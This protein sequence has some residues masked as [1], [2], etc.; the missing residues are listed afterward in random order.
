MQTSIGEDLN[1]VD[2]KAAE[3]LR[4]VRED[5]D[6]LEVLGQLRSNHFV[7]RSDESPPKGE[8]LNRCPL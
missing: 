8:V 4:Q 5:A 6:T 1:R 2:A 7:S 3:E